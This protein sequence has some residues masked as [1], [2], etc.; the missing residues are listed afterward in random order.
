ME[1]YMTRERLSRRSFLGLVG[2]TLAVAA[3]AP[4]LALAQ[5]D[6][7][8]MAGAIEHPT[9]P[10]ELILRVE[11]VGGFVPVAYTISSLP[12]FS[13]YGDGRAIFTG[14]MIDIFPSPAVTNLRQVVL[15]EAGIQQVLA[16][17]RDAGLLDGDKEYSNDMIADAATAVFTVNAGGKTTT[18]SAYALGLADNPRWTEEERAAIAKLQEFASQTLD[19]SFWLDPA[20]IAS[21]DEEYPIDRLQVLAEPTVPSM[22]TPEVSDPIEN[23]PPMDWPLSTPIAEALPITD[24]FGPDLNFNC[25]VITGAD[26]A[27]LLTAAQQANVLTPWVS[28]GNSY[29]LWFRPL[30]PDETGC[31]PSQPE[32]GAT[33]RREHEKGTACRAP[34]RPNRRPAGR[35]RPTPSAGAR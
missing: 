16:A 6:A 1:R 2:G 34:T 30:L 7:T 19:V 28:E 9:E 35:T 10:D 11:Y 4:T 32:S 29:I 24:L 18:V 3:K 13:L 20:N 17:A 31:P 23:Q 14:P 15:T 33:H 27:T 8:P 25:G 26:A 12:L 22:A 5:S 21:G